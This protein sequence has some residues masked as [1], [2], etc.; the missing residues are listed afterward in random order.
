MLIKIKPDVDKWFTLLFYL[1][2]PPLVSILIPLYNGIEYLAETL[3][4]IK[5]QTY[6]NYEILI[7]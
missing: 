1:S 7:V 4:S 3:N 5:Q 6:N 2:N